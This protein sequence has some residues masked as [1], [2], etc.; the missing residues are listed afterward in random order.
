M[1][2]IFGKQCENVWTDS[3][4]YWWQPM[5]GFYDCRD[6]LRFPEKGR[7][8]ST[9]W[10]TTIFSRSSCT[11]N[12]LWS[13]SVTSLLIPRDRQATSLTLLYCGLLTSQGKVVQ[14]AKCISSHDFRHGRKEKQ[15]VTYRNVHTVCVCVCVYICTPFSMSVLIWVRRSSVPGVPIWCR[16][17]DSVHSAVQ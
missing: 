10:V 6:G 2:L 17:T 11:T 1:K 9:S 16:C 7:N 12:D 3:S 15:T 13:Y 5:A 8:I 4:G 14:L